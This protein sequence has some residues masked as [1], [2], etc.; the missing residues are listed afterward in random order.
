MGKIKSNATLLDLSKT[1]EQI[2]NLRIFFKKKTNQETRSSSI[3]TIEV[4]EEPKY[5]S[6][7]LV[8]TI[9]AYKKPKNPPFYVSMKIIDK[10]DH[11]CLIDRGSGH[12][13][14]PKTIME[15]LGLSCTN[16]N[17]RN[18]LAFNK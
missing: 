2:Q 6:K 9:V 16:E 14:M 12:N 18:M 13:A 4:G 7:E 8:G 1:L 15:E 11:C 17:P 5:D 3:T 10:I